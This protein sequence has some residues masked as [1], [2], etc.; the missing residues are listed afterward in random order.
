MCI[1]Q[2][3]HLYQALVDTELSTEEHYG[4]VVKELVKKVEPAKNASKG[5]H[6]LAKVF[7]HFLSP[8]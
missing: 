7:F 4:D 3:V 1:L 5:N 2:A 8:V 6:K